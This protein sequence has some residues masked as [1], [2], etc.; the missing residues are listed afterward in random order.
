MISI[1]DLK[2]LRFLYEYREI[3]NLSCNSFGTKL[4]TIF[5]YNDS[6]FWIILMYFIMLYD[7][8]II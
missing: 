6:F 2:D 3:G 4:V 7:Q 8:M 1:T 5:T